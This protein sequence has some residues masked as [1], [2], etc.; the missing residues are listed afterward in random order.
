MLENINMAHLHDGPAPSPDSPQPA[1]FCAKNVLLVR[2]HGSAE[3][4]MR[5]CWR[6]PHWRLRAIGAEDFTQFI[7][8]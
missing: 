4:E 5:V 1:L 8:V 3:E 7:K 2:T 6:Q